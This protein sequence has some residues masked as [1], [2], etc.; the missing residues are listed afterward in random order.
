MGTPD[1]NTIVTPM[2]VV[3]MSTMPANGVVPMKV[4]FF[5]STGSPIS[6]LTDGVVTGAEV[7]LTGYTT[8]TAGA[9]AATD[10]L[11]AALAKLEART[12]AGPPTGANVLLTGYAIGTSAA[13]AA[14]D[15]VNQALAKIEARLVAHSI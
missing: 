10:S 11:N 9:L 3:A 12:L 1:P 5:T 6:F 7:V 14:T 8:G 2:S 15:T 4:A 13:L